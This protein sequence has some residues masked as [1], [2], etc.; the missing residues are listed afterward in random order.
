MTR[1]IMEILL[2]TQ[3]AT[4]SSALYNPVLPATK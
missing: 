4:A 2:V 1:Q 3:E